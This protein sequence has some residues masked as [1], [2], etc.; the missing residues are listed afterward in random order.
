MPVA[1]V[2][3]NDAASS[4]VTLG[5][6]VTA[7]NTVVVAVACLGP[8][9]ATGVTGVTLGGS[10]DNFAPVTPGPPAVDTT[11]PND[12]I[13]VSLWADPNCAGGPT[14]IVVTGTGVV[15]TW[16]W[17]FSGLS[18]TVDNWQV[19]PVPT[20]QPSWVTA[21]PQ[22]TVAAEAWLAVT[23]A[24][25]QV[26]GETLTVN[27]VTGWTLQNAYNGTLSTYFWGAQAG[28]QTVNT[29]GAPAWSGAF[30]QPSFSVT[31][32]LALGAALPAAPAAAAVTGA[33]IAA[34]VSAQGG[35]LSVAASVNAGA[36]VNTGAVQMTT[37]VNLTPTG[38]K[39]GNYTAKP[40]DFVIAAP[41]G[42]NQMIVTFPA[43]APDRSLVGVKLANITSVSVTTLTVQA[44]GSDVFDVAPAGT[45]AILLTAGATFIAQYKQAAGTWYI[46]SASYAG[47]APNPVTPTLGLLPAAP[48]ANSL[49][50]G[51]MGFATWSYD[52]AYLNSPLAGTA[53]TSGKVYLVLCPVRATVAFSTFEAWI[54]AAG[55]G[56]T[57]NQNF[58][59]VYS[60]AGTL[61]SK[62]ADV[63]AAFG[64]TGALNQSLNPN[65]FATPPFVWAAFLSNGTTPPSLVRTVSQAGILA[66][67]NP[68]L[69]NFRLGTVS[70]TFT[71]LPSSFS[72]SAAST[73]A[74]AYFVGLS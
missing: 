14:A 43:G 25:N 29:V 56:L 74:A 66:T 3:E 40:G 63:T 51:D 16:V 6:G 47:L 11:S 24:A 68:G 30:S 50:P 60:Y 54:T 41:T 58:V 53:L 10:A 34:G 15:A 27:N 65:A 5:A 18:G 12:V 17:E 32:L 31:V 69:V 61:L 28:Y 38:V 42:G 59:G 71:S 9:P 36:T 1:L 21:L 57:A 67:G 48:A 4:S 70:G 55:S 52:P 72:P 62:S 45:T 8:T 44:S 22:T 19:F 13:T 39:T 73:A 2:Q 64:S 23:C 49:L 46:Q 26:A 33:P 7:G 37:P 20:Y 35:S